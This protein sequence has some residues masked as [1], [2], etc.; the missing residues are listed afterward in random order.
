MKGIAT[1]IL[2]ILVSFIFAETGTL[3]VTISGLEPI[4]GNLMLSLH[5]GPAGFPGTGETRVKAL[6][7]KV[8]SDSL[9]VFFGPIPYGEYAIAIIHDIDGDG[10]LKSN[11]LGIPQEPVYFSNN[12]RPGFGPPKFKA[13]SFIIDSPLK[14]IHIDAKSD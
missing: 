2:L 5:N 9:E 14:T 13:A 1:C 10:K 12:V 11:E 3:T 7:T 6:M 4:E 8:D